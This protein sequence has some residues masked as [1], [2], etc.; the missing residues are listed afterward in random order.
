MQCDKD[1]ATQLLVDHIDN[2]PVPSV[3]SQLEPEPQLLHQYLHTLFHRNEHAVKDYE[4]KMVELYSQYDYPQL[5]KF[6]T[7]SSYLPLQK[8]FNICERKKLWPEMIYFHG[9][10]G[11]PKEGLKLLLDPRVFETEEAP[12]ESPEFI[13]SEIL[14]AH[15]LNSIRRGIK[16]FQK[17]NTDQLLQV[18]TKFRIDIDKSKDH[19]KEN[20]VEAIKKKKRS[21]TVQKAI[22]FI[23]TYDDEIWDYFIDMA[24]EK[25]DPGFISD[26]LNEIGAYIDP[27]RLIEKIPPRM[28]IENLRDRIVKIISD[29]NLHVKILFEQKSLIFL[30]GHT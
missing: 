10:M 22:D 14:M 2:I 15:D 4:E 21:T 8:A 9:R 26:L 20:L 28:K 17:L 29:Y 12:K 27:L 18:C 1:K 3:V 23:Q 7:N 11:Q 16:S 19:K 5:M 30:K 13:L 24:V 6:L 25:K